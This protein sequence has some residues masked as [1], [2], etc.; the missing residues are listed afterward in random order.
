[1]LSSSPPPTITTIT[2]AYPLRTRL[3]PEPGL[4]ILQMSV[5]KMS[6][7]NAHM[8]KQDGPNLLK[9]VYKSVVCHLESLSLKAIL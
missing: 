3:A 4:L 5:G 2:V 8:C 9:L 7:Q 1:M 6:A